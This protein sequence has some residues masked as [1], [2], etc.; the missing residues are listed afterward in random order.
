MAINKKLKEKKSSK[1]QGKLL[2]GIAKQG[3][4]KFQS[5]IGHSGQYMEG[6]GFMEGFF[7]GRKYT[8][9]AVGRKGDKNYSPATA[10]DTMSK[11]IKDKGYLEPNAHA[12]NLTKLKF[13]GF[14]YYSP[15]TKKVSTYK[16]GTSAPP[17]KGGKGGKGT[18]PALETVG[19]LHNI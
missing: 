5:P 9:L 3:G 4:G 7:E 2:K 13:K 18:P 10:Y 11:S 1:K 12:K 8:T 17:S 19:T 15:V 6:G 14:K 16:I